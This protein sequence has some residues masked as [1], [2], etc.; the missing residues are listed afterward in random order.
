MLTTEKIIEH[1]KAGGEVLAL[2]DYY[3][4]THKQ[5][6]EL[7][8]LKINYDKPQYQIDQFGDHQ[9]YTFSMPEKW[10]LILMN[11]TEYHTLTEVYKALMKGKKLR[12]TF[13]SE[14]SYIYLNKDR[15]VFSNNVHAPIEINDIPYIEF[16]I[17]EFKIDAYTGKILKEGFT[18]G[19]I[20][21]PWTMVK[22]IEDAAKEEGF[23]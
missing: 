1:L 14:N 16:K 15:V 18:V 3:T 13:W 6:N 19:C 2:E 12:K 20:T 21:V 17:K 4:N 8:R 7:V 10:R 9:F 5:R 11:K 23:M 22:E